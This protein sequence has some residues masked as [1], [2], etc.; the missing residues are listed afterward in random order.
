M[1]R[2]RSMMAPSRSSHSQ[3]CR[4]HSLDGSTLRT[5]LLYLAPTP[6]A[7]PSTPALASTHLL[8]LGGGTRCSPSRSGLRSATPTREHVRGL[9]SGRAIPLATPVLEHQLRGHRG[10]RL[11][12]RT[13][14]RCFACP[15]SGSEAGRC[16]SAVEIWLAV[17]ETSRQR[18]KAPCTALSLSLSPSITCEGCL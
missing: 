13:A 10:R 18:A 6:T 4:R 14:Q 8:A 16:I 2:R 9:V 5:H 12:C 7:Q 15:C 1:R 17:D 3:R 11:A